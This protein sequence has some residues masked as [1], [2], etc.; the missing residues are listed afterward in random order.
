MNMRN[1][2]ESG[3]T[4]IITAFA[5][6]EIKELKEMQTGCIS[7]RRVNRIIA[8]FQKLYPWQ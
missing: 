1:I 4:P 3:N 6:V 5:I 7:V 2:L 8:K